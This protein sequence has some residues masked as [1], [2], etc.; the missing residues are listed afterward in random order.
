MLFTSLDMLNAIGQTMLH[1]ET[2]HHSNFQTIMGNPTNTYEFRAGYCGLTT[3]PSEF[4][5]RTVK[6]LRETENLVCSLTT[7]YW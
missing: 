3:I 5:K 2:A 4:Q 6:N 7:F 1:L